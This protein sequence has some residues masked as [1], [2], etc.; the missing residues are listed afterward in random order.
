MLAVGEELL[1]KVSYS[2]FNLGTIWLKVT[3]RV[4]RGD[5]V[6]YKA[7][8][9]MRSNP[10]IP[11]IDLSIR[12]FSEFDERIFSYA[13]SS[14]DSSKEKLYVRKVTFDEANKRALQEDRQL[15]ASGIRQTYKADTIRVPGRYQDG[16]SL[17]YYARQ[18]VFRGKPDTVPIVIEKK[19]DTAVINFTNSI[20]PVEIDA[21]DYPIETI[22]FDGQ[23]KFVGVFGMT[24]GFEGWFSNDSARVPILAKMNVILGSI[25]I[26]LVSWKRPGWQ[27]PRARGGMP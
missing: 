1:Y 2:F 13:F 18:Q 26:Q 3:D 27:P 10:S 14:L 23:A 8:A 25:R 22:H 5:R 9:H 4:Q 17:F 19:Q 11:F 16:L 6:V 24:G 20:V 12:F 21:V 7:T 15:F